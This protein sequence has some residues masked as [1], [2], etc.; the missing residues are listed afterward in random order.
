MVAAL[1]DY[2]KTVGVVERIPVIPVGR[3][4]ELV[5]NRRLFARPSALL[6]TWKAISLFR[7]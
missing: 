1:N 5:S 6:I 4:L 3:S 2:Y 7:N